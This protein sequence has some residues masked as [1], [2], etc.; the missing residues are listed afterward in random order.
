M[1]KLLERSDEYEA[2]GVVRSDKAAAQLREWGAGESQIVNGD[3]LGAGGAAA[4]AAALEGADRLVIATS[5]VPKIKPL[6]LVPVLLAK[7]F[8]REGVRPKFTF[9][10]GQMPEQID[11]VGQKMQVDAAAAAG[12]QKVVLVGS[13]GGTDRAN[14][15]NTIGDGD[16]LVWKRRAEKY[17]VDLGL[18]YTILHP[19]GLKDEEGGCRQ[20]VLDVDDNLISSKSKYRAIPRADV[21]ELCVQALRLADRRA[22]DCVAKDVGDGAPTTDFAALFEGMPA[23]CGYADME[24]DAVLEA[25]KARG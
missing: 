14:F 13:M 9:K 22:V 15:L 18:N 16:I 12:V 5:A 11:W 25:A 21:A 4:L 24:G 23:S 10:A 20:I 6:S 2:V 3:L 19:G 7:L 1:R 8:R 17:L